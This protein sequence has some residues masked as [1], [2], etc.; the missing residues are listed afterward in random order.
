MGV[1][2]YVISLRRKPKNNSIIFVGLDN[3]GKTTLLRQLS[4]EPIATASV[5][6]QG[7]IIRSI[8]V[9]GI[10]VQA[11]DVGG[12][13]QVRPYWRQ[14]YS[15]AAGVVFV[16]D[17]SNRDRLEEAY[18]ELLQLMEEEKVLGAPL[19]IFANKQDRMNAVS[20]E[21]IARDIHITSMKQS[22][23]KIQSCSAVTG[24]GV[25]EGMRWLVKQLQFDERASKEREREKASKARHQHRRT[26]SKRKKEQECPPQP[27][28]PQRGGVD[29]TMMDASLGSMMMNTST[30]NNNRN[31]SSQRSSSTLRKREKRR[32]RGED[33]AGAGSTVNATASPPH[34]LESSPSASTTT[35][36]SPVLWHSLLGGANAPPGSAPPQESLSLTDGKTPM[37]MEHQ[38]HPQHHHMAAGMNHQ[39]CSG[40][41]PSSSSRPSP[42]PLLLDGRVTGGDWVVPA[43]PFHSENGDGHVHVVHEGEAEAV[44]RPVAIANDQKKILPTPPPTATITPARSASSPQPQ[45]SGANHHN[46]VGKPPATTFSSLTPRGTTRQQSVTAAQQQSKRSSRITSTTTLL[47]FGSLVG[48]DPEADPSLPRSQL[49]QPPRALLS[50]IAV[51]QCK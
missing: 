29:T 30:T 24:A 49:Q 10:K 11:F 45:Q 42:S 40:P 37:T 34:H 1:L 8:K 7:F 51:Q 15:D 16:I 19:L 25:N 38:Q 33:G 27:L 35:S 2:E 5:P 14:Y 17:S 46:S 20:T 4:G 48:M 41:A 36:G 47:S 9:G 31:S 18:E 44:R 6:T 13:D 21:Q 3:A 32:E 50:S 28:P 23:W 22:S 43:D 26:S 12:Q 39:P